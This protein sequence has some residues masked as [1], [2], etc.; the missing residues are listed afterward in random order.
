MVSTFWA[1]SMSKSVVAACAGEVIVVGD[2]DDIRGAGVQGGIGLEDSRAARRNPVILA[3]RSD[4]AERAGR[5]IE[6]DAQTSAP[7][8]PDVTLFTDVAG[9]RQR[10]DDINIGRARCRSCNRGQPATAST[11]R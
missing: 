11:G 1:D 8:W 10:V 6:I 7:S 9:A 4:D 5:R 3:R 2:R